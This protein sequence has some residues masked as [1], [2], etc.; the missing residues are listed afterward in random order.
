MTTNV[1][2]EITENVEGA[3]ALLESAMQRAATAKARALVATLEVA[4]QTIGDAQDE[5]SVTS[6][7]EEIAA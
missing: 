1:H 6:T 3:C 2:N 7:E 4:L 5:L